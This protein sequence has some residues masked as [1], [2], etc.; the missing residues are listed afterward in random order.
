[1]SSFVF[2]E[3]TPSEFFPVPTSFQMRSVFLWHIPTIRESQ[4]TKPDHAANRAASEP[5]HRIQVQ[6][7]FSWAGSLSSDGMTRMQN[8]NIVCHLAC[9][10]DERR[11]CA[12]IGGRG[13]TRFYP[14]CLSW[15][16]KTTPITFFILA[17]VTCRLVVAWIV[18]FPFPLHL[19]R[20]FYLW[21][22]HIGPS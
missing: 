20:H 22:C 21:I 12:S 19:I 15:S 16:A 14:G 9:S 7:N 5:G 6:S 10:C 2:T 11:R 1:M 4:H 17:R 13:D 18:D 3:I 8:Q